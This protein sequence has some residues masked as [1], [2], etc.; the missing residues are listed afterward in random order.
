MIV[1]DTNVI[2]YLFL[3]GQYSDLSERLLEH[4]PDWMAPRLWRSVFAAGFRP[5]LIAQSGRFVDCG[6]ANGSNTMGP[7]G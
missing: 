3:T 2:A 4:D 1:V 5:G 7:D 6:G